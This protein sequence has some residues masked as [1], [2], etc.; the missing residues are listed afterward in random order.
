MVTF[1]ADLSIPPTAV[2]ASTY[3]NVP[4]AGGSAVAPTPPLTGVL[5]VTAS[6]DGFFSSVDGQTWLM[7]ASPNPASPI[8][9]IVWSSS[10]SAWFASAENGS[11]TYFA[12]SADGLTWTALTSLTGPYFRVVAIGSTLWTAN[13]SG[14]SKISTDGGVTW[15]TG[16]TVPI[17]PAFQI[18]AQ[19]GTALIASNG[20]GVA[21]IFNSTTDGITTTA[22][23]VPNNAFIAVA[24]PH[25]VCISAGLFCVLTNALAN[26]ASGILTSATGATGT[27]T[28]YSTPASMAL[29]TL[30]S[31][32]GNGSGTWIVLATDNSAAY[33]TDNM[34]TWTDMASLA[35]RPLRISYSA[36][37]G[38]F[39]VGSNGGIAKTQITANP[40]LGW[41]TP[42]TLP[43][44]S[45]A[46]GD[47][48]VRG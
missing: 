24:Q 36:T 4:F 14:G 38:I 22:V 44:G 20:G 29:K 10:Y 21:A 28:A 17:V 27:W 35:D 47:M 26:N 37:L 3:L 40:A 31:I 41:S 5:F 1:Y 2:K 39:A 33:S 46:I 13:Q 11:T 45:G 23:T 6:V 30:A 32:A 43:A 7:H 18:A 15:T 16:A 25:G 8:D 42:T 12:T 19:N 34:A 9:Q 48:G